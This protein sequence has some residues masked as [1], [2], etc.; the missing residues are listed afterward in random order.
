MKRNERKRRKWHYRNL[1]MMAC[2]VTYLTNMSNL[3][4]L[5]IYLDPL[6]HF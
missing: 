5:S 3:G 1:Y 6:T 4:K 2:L